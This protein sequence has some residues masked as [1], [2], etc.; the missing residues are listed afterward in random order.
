MSWELHNLLP[1]PTDGVAALD[2]IIDRT[3]SQPRDAIDFTNK[4]LSRATGHPAVTWRNIYD[5]EIE[6]SRD[7]LKNVC[8]EWRDPYPG[9]EKVL[10]H[11]RGRSATLE[12]DQLADVLEDI[13]LLV[14]DESSPIP[15]WLPE[16]VLPIWGKGSGV[17]GWQEI[18]GA[19]INL[20][21]EIGFLGV[22]S[23]REEN[24]AYS[25][26]K[27]TRSTSLNSNDPYDSSWY[28]IHPAFRQA[29]G[30]Q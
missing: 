9:L 8:D 13:A 26:T 20:L 6:Y 10:E 5:A 25:C 19:L 27:P 18:Y 15:Q 29:L 28:E 3:L 21:Y 4:C 17:S 1:E 30:I 11:F 22:G 16:Y 7:R 24:V 2:Y 12:H 23:Q 14:E